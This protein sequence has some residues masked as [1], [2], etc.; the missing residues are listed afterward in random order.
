M[1]ESEI[2]EKLRLVK[3]L[4]AGTRYQGEREAAQTVALKLKKRLDDLR[5]AAPVVEYSFSMS[6]L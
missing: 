2:I 5:S 1:S 6:D 3:A 4:W